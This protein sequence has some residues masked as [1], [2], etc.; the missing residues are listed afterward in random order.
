MSVVSLS[1]KAGELPVADT[2]PLMAF[3]LPVV[4]ITLGDVVALGGF[5]IV[6]ARFIIDMRRAK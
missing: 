1:T 3:P 6:L 2:I 4:Q 5:A